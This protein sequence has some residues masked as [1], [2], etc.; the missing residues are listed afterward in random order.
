MSPQTEPLKEQK[1]EDV[2]VSVLKRKPTR[3][4]DIWEHFTKAKVSERG[5][6]R[7]I[8]NYCG[9]DYASDTKRVGTSSMWGHLKN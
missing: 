6:P 4:S 3:T 8:C 7:S 9:K 2:N 1:T 5:E